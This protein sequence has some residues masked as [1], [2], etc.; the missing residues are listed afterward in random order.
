MGD[1]KSMSDDQFLAA[2]LDSSMPPAGFD[3]L[4]HM[5]AAWLLLQ[6]RPFEDAVAETCNAIA[7]LA[8]RLGVPEKYNRT[9]SEAL[10]RLM[11]HGGASN[12]ALSWPDFLAANADLVGDARRV[13]V[14]HYSDE[15]LYSEAARECFT[16]PDRQPLP[17]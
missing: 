7:R 4:G 8:T 9:L 13:L 16:A 17:L 5:R 14:R 3:H 11:A 10:V 2:F 1:P 15:T 12:R 6:R